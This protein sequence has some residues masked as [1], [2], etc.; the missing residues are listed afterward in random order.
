MKRH[1][2][3][4]VVLS[5][6]IISYIFVIVPA[7][8]STILRVILGIPVI[9]FT[10][11]YMTV[12]ALFPKKQSL[13]LTERVALSLGLSIAIVPL[14][15]L[16]LNYTH[17]IKPFPMWVTI[18]T[19]TI[20]MIFITNYRRENIS[21]D[22]IFSIV[23]DIGKFRDILFGLGSGRGLKNNINKT[24]TIT[25]VLLTIFTIGTIYFVTTTPK[26]GERFTEFYILNGAND[27]NY[28]TDLTVNSPTVYLMGI[29]NYE[30][31]PTDYIVKTVLDNDTLYSENIKLEYNGKLE[32]NITF[33][34]NKIGNDMKLQFLLFKNNGTEPYRR[35]HLW[36]NVTE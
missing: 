4:S 14:L 19:Y 17:N 26:I 30:Y 28:Q 1:L 27:T 32:K 9:L 11:G 33:T 22:E 34:P 10:T 8:E 35:L 23:E 3:L 13:R 18:C 16:L 36:I 20:I 25:I 21:D 7:L 31:Y 12:A 2:D 15:S 29:N 6:T 24:L 5:W